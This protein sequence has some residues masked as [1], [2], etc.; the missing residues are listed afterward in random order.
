MAKRRIKYVRAYVNNGGYY[1]PVWGYTTVTT[2]A[3]KSYFNK[4]H[5][6]SKVSVMALVLLEFLCEE[7]DSKTNIVHH[8]KPTRD[9]FIK[10]LKT[11]TGRKYSDAAVKK[12]FRQLAKC[13]LLIYYNERGSSHVN[14]RHYFKGA[15]AD[16]V[17]LLEN[18]YK[19]YFVGNPTRTNLKLALGL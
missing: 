5:K 18:L 4:M 1:F 13:G 10:L 7:M 9:K 8:N 16:R 12:A 2:N 6:T 3:V 14:P 11:S 17:K 15:E 19:L